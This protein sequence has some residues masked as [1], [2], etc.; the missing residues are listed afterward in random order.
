MT[1]WRKSSHSGT[2]QGTDCVELARLASAVV[3]RDSKA[4]EAGHLS[5]PA[6][7]FADLIARVKR[8]ELSV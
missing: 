7:T 8:G 6:D 2:T 5:L 4:P 1:K 3:V